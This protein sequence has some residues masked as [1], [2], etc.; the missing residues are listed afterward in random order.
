MKK[1]LA[2]LLICTGLSACGADNQSDTSL[3]KTTEPT[4]ITTTT[5]TTTE[6]TPSPIDNR[7]T[8]KN[9]TTTKQNTTTA[10]QEV[11]RYDITDQI[12]ELYKRNDADNSFCYKGIVEITNTG[13]TNLFIGDCKFNIEDDSGHLIDV[14]N[15]VF[16]TACVIAPGEK[17][18]LYN[19]GPM[20]KDNV[21]FSNGA[22]LSAECKIYKTNKA[23]VDYEISDTDLKEDNNTNLVV[24]GRLT[25]NSEEVENFVLIHALL[26]DENDK[27]I[28]IATTSANDL[29]PNADTS[30]EAHLVHYSNDPELINRVKT[31]GV[32]SRKLYYSP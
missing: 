32:M 25:N 18:Y 30:F 1:Q 24:T 13:D 19:S 21:D 7:I 11:V 5:V 9:T 15:L 12:F 26:Y 29:Q 6:S 31:Y 2:I 3:K 14:D 28:Y 23:I 17:S 16:K 22:N 20:P 10:K 8:T 27:V 4:T